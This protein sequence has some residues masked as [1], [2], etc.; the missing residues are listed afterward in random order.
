MEHTRYEMNNN[1]KI[2][3]FSEPR[4]VSSNCIELVFAFDR[5]LSEMITYFRYLVLINHNN[6]DIICVKYML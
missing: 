3:R 1:L 5:L 2:S 4:S 6:A